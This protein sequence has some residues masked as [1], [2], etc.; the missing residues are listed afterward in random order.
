MNLPTL[1]R[2]LS[3]FLLGAQTLTALTATPAT[4]QSLEELQL[5]E[6]PLVLQSQG[7]FFVGGERVQQ[8]RE[9]MGSFVDSGHITVNQMY[10]RY[11]VPPQ[12]KTAVVMIHGMALTGKCWE[13][14]PDG[15]L[16][17][18]EYFVRQG[19]SVYVADQV[20]RGRSGFDQSVFNRVRVGQT[21][22]SSTPSLRRSS[23]ENTWP[24]FRIGSQEGVPFQPSLYPVSSID[25]A[26]KQ[27]V[28]DL[29]DTVPSPNPSY[30]ALAD[31]SS[32]LKGAV[33]IS[34]SQ[35]GSFPLE[36]ALIDPTGI[37][38]MV[39]L[40]PGGISDSYTDQQIAVLA[41]IPILVMFGDYLGAAPEGTG[42]S[43]QAAYDSGEA[44]V[45]RVK[46]A[47]GEAAMLHLPAVGIR[48]N[49]HML[50]QDTNSLELADLVLKW[51]E[52]HNVE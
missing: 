34:H 15:R 43:W 6:T 30:R 35:S 31:L 21:P 5:P 48:G 28:P 9:E 4:A 14:T 38:A 19:R 12:A 39:L 1:S 52:E 46:A 25:E 33:L 7:S 37:K 26:S 11:M 10:V 40:E 49:S 18:D 13:T 17:W 8:S 47:G 2:N 45:A 20:G 29:S 24:N 51:L 23:N 27:G 44:F 32:R 3:S 22:A 16:G 50:M 36:A 42:H 41:K